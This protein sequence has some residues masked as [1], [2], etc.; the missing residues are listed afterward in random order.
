MPTLVAITR[1]KTLAQ[2]ADV[3][4]TKEAGLTQSDE[5][6]KLR[7]RLADLE[8]GQKLGLIWR[9]IP[10]DVES[11]L[12]DEVP[13]LVREKELDVVGARPSDSPHIL[14]GRQPSR[15]ARL[16]SHTFGSRRRDL[17]RSALQ[18]GQPIVDVQQQLHRQGRLI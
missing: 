14:I 5:L 10:E 11:L 15:P 4:N 1:E 7:Q 8:R 2:K 12:Q 13:V 3:E 17:H 6:E 9:D 16:A 18:H